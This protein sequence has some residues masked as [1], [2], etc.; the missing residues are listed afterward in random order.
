MWND[1][2][3]LALVFLAA[4]STHPVRALDR[5]DIGR[6]QIAAAMNEAG[7]RVSTEQIIL[8]TNIVATSRTPKLH[9]QSVQHWGDHQLRVRCACLG[10]GECLPF[11]VSVS[12]QDPDSLPSLQEN[13]AVANPKQMP[14]AV[15]SGTSAVLLFDTDRTHISI[16]V[17]CLESGAVGSMVR[18]ESKDHRRTFVAEVV[19]Q[20]VLKGKL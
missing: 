11:F 15:R 16:P 18:V 4:M 12:G 2:S 7:L 9:V 17:V 3:I 10:P 5:F 19:S 6:G 20:A 1:K 14:V 13:S 8:L